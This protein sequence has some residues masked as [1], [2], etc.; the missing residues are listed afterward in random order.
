MAALSPRNEI[1]PISSPPTLIPCSIRTSV[2]EIAAA[3]PI[4]S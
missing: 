1:E 3:I 4:R 2:S